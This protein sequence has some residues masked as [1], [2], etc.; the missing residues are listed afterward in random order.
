VDPGFRADGAVVMDVSLPH[1]RFDSP[2]KIVGFYTRALDGLRALPGVHAAAAVSHLPLGGKAGDWFLEAEGR[3]ASAPSLPSPEFAV[4]SAD[5]FRALGIGVRQGRGFDESDGPDSPPS[6]VVS[7]E[8]ARIFW[9]GEGSVLG[10]RVRFGGAPPGRTLPWMT[11]VGVVDDVHRAALSAAPRPSYYML[12]RQFPQIIGDAFSDMTLVVRTMGPP[13]QII[14]PAR[15][16]IAELDPELAV[17]NV[18]TLAAVVS[19]S[20]ARPRFAM[21]VLG[22]FGLSSLLLAA[23]GVYGVLSYA[24]TRRRREM[25]VRMAIGA[26]PREVRR[27]ALHAGVRLAAIGVA[28]GLALALAGGRAV[29]ALLFEV[30]ATDPIT[31]VAVGT[32]LLGAAVLASWL[33]ARRAT[34]VSPAEV[35]RGD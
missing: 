27:L 26:T 1:A 30:S 20:V 28:V 31:L 19:S 17:A 3:P 21:A 29:R 5:V 8:M 7:R 2:T 22:A 16:V 11:V 24:M 34:L 13:S 9:P 18:R 14:G 4:A 12:D 23:V 35:L 6:V 25:A 15:A 33:P 10:R 32:V